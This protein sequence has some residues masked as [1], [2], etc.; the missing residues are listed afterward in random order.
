MANVVVSNNI[1]IELSGFFF[2]VMEKNYKWQYNFSHLKI[3]DA[4][5]NHKWFSLK[6]VSNSKCKEVGVLSDR[7]KLW[8]N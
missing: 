4:E 1:T 8:E 5:D 3:F 6:P 7:I 2:K